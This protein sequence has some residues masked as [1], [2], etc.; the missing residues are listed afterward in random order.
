MSTEPSRTRLLEARLRGLV[1]RRWPDAQ[2]TLTDLP[3]G[4]GLV[5]GAVAWVLIDADPLKS[6]GPAL[7][8]AS[9]HGATELHLLTDTRADVLA[10]RA[11]LFLPPP[12]VWQIDG[13]ELAEA[14]PAAP[15]QSPPALPAPELAELLVDAGLEVFVE[16]GLVRG[17]VNGLEV[18]RIV[19]GASTSGVP[20]DAPLLEVGVGHAD[21]E[22]TAM[23]HGRLSPTDQLAR[24]AEIVRAHRQPGAERHP[25]NQLAPE[26]WLR[27]RL[28]AEPSRLGLTSL[29]QADPAVPRPNLRDPA[30]AVALGEAPDGSRV[31]V[32]CSIG[33]DLDLVPAAAD[34]RLALAPDARLLL[35]VPQRDA[36]RVTHD[37]ADRL[38]H[39]AEV[40]TVDDDWRL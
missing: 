8:W 16:S 24:V 5:D 38:A 17:E 18:A 1:R 32:A 40:V 34:A 25:L 36:H 30:I 15:A 2:P 10:R 9:R 35:V 28:I 20:L 33:V 39:P 23:L 21:R 6:F 22:L 3:G 37:L 19:H 4:A 31:V 11:G 14:S 29:R 13:T 27:A 7:I 12:H 26:R